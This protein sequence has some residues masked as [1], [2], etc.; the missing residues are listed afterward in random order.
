MRALCCG[1][2]LTGTPIEEEIPTPAPSAVGDEEVEGEGESDDDGLS[3]GTIV[4]ILAGVILPLLVGGG[5][6]VKFGCKEFT[7]N[8]FNCD[9]KPTT[10]NTA[11][12]ETSG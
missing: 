2:V 10:E 1:R 11:N 7:I 4:G 3:T 12:N 8:C 6:A 9:K 5:L